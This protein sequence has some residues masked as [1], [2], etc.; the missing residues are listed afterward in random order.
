M[1]RHFDDQGSTIRPQDAAKRVVPVQLLDLVRAVEGSIQGARRLYRPNK[2]LWATDYP[3]PNGFFP[4]AP[5]MLRERRKGTSPETQRGVFAGGAMGFLRPST[6]LANPALRAV[7][8]AAPARRA[9][10]VAVHPSREAEKPGSKSIKTL[11]RPIS[12]RAVLCGGFQSNTALIHFLQ[13]AG[14]F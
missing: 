14:W 8:S 9:G 13:R 7:G 11:S 10:Q 1:D 6:E 3:H 12:L 2:I 5:D 4:G